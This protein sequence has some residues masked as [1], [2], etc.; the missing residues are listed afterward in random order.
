MSKNLVGIK[1]GD[2]NIKIVSTLQHR[3][4]LDANT[5]V[6]YNLDTN[7]A[8]P[9]SYNGLGYMNL[10]SMIFEIQIL[11]HDFKKEQSKKPA[12][13]NLLFIEE[14]EAHTHPQMQYIF[15]EKY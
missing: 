8:L 6:M 5:T 4:L 15:I 12:D 14:P 11:L 7:H 1:K 2:S 10:I 3:E 13:I 9:E